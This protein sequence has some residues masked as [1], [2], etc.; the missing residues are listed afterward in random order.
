MCG[1]AGI[2]DFDGAVAGADVTEM[3]R[4]IHHRGPDDRG[5]YEDAGVALGACRLAI[6]DL[7]PAGH[8]PMRDESGRYALVYNGEIYNYRELRAELE[9]LGHRFA[10]HT[11]TEVVLEAFREWGER[12]VE[13]FN[14]MWAFAL[15]DSETRE[16]FCSRDRFGIKPFYYRL[17]GGSRFTFGSELKVFGGGPSPGL[18]PNLSVVRDFIEFGAID[19]VS[20][21]FFDGILKLPAAHSATVRRGE[22]RLSRYW[23]LE[24]STPPPGDSVEAVRELLR[25]AIRLHLRS[26]VPIGTCLSGGLDSSAIA[27]GVDRIWRRDGEPPADGEVRQQTFTAYFTDSGYDERPYARLVVEQIGAQPAWITF[28]PRDLLENLPHIV[29]AQEEPFGSASIVAQWF[30]MRRAHEDGIKVMLDG[31]GGDE[32]FAGYHTNFGPRF[33]DLLLR[34]SLRELWREAEGFR[35]LHSV[36]RREIATSIVRALVSEETV[37]R[38]R[39][40]RSR[41]HSLL[42]DDLHGLDRPARGE[43]STLDG[44]LRRHLE[45]LLLRRQLPELLRYEDRNSMV[46][47]IE[48]RVPLLDHRLVE[49][50]FSLDPRDLIQRGQTKVVLRRAFADILPQAV[51]DRHDKIGFAAPQARWLRGELGDFAQEVFASPA[52]DQRGLIDADAARA[53]LEQHRRGDVAAGFEVWRALNVELW[54]ATFFDAP[55]AR[56]A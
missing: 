42:H 50:L 12:C 19:H 21:T 47:S 37:D 54:A 13:R 46:H 31:Q 7:S 14:G 44:R 3:L 22:V 28:S 1:I 9:S 27:C 35:D 24:Q 23:S 29:A 6:I 20:E 25:D 41:A 34:G 53:R 43:R 5:V 56:A 45:D 33:A 55:L 48:A 26:D 17:D 38:V 8:Q 18:R 39:S 15:W 2:L 51:R 49:L 32:I 36:R 40:R 30:V 52:F 16:L 10:S 4:R 11:D